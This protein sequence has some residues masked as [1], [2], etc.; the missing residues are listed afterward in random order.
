M[1]FEDGSEFYDSAYAITP[2]AKLSKE[3]Q[4]LVRDRNATLSEVVNNAFESTFTSVPFVLYDDYMEFKA[5]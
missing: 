4:Q 5:N 3:A 1:T 2:G